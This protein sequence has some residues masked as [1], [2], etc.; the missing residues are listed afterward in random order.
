MW[1]D[2]DAPHSVP[3]DLGRAGMGYQKKGAVQV[4]APSDGQTYP[5]GA[6]PFGRSFVN[7]RKTNTGMRLS[8][9]GS[10]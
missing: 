8:L 3:F 10:G 1:A 7:N 4:G 5:T 6:R 2:S 9:R